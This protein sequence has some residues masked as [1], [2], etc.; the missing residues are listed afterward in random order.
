MDLEP[1]GR[2]AAIEVMLAL[3]VTT[4]SPSWRERG[5][6]GDPAGRPLFAW[7]YQAEIWGRPAG[8]PYGDLTRAPASRR[9]HHRPAGSS[10]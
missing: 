4:I 2:A 9:L 8:R 6:R 10:V 3:S 1:A 7:P 5:S